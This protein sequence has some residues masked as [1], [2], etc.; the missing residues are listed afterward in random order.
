MNI[1]LEGSSFK[2][3]LQGEISKKFA[4]QFR[5]MLDVFDMLWPFGDLSHIISNTIFSDL[6]CVVC[7]GN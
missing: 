7:F 3:S 4:K 6:V 2:K 1:S 5:L